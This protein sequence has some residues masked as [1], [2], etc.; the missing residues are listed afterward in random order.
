MMIGSCIHTEQGAFM[1]SRQN[2][3]ADKVKRNAEYAKKFKKKRPQAPRRSSPAFEAF[4][5]IMPAMNPHSSGF[6]GPRE[7]HEAVCATCQVAT[8]VPFKP[9]AGRPVLCRSCFQKAA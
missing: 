5:G 1:A 3:K 6:A 4:L 2:P 8:T 9:T 7:M